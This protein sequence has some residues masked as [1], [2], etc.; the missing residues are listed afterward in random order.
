MTADVRE[1]RPVRA[2]S[3]TE[4]TA[5]LSSDDRITDSSRKYAAVGQNKEDIDSSV[6]GSRL[7]VGRSAHSPPRAVHVPGSSTNSSSSSSS[8]DNVRRRVGARKQTDTGSVPWHLG[9]IGSLGGPTGGGIARRILH[10]TSSRRGNT[11]EI[12]PRMDVIRHLYR[13]LFIVAVSGIVCQICQIALGDVRRD[14]SLVS[15]SPHP[16]SICVVVHLFA[17]AEVNRYNKH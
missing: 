9:A 7:D 1:A 5:T 15:P 4:P 17:R 16:T 14:T 3:G 10:S 11:Y 2:A 8:I 12:S 13:E 6:P